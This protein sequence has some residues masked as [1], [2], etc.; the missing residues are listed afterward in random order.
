M[1]VRNVRMDAELPYLEMEFVEG[2]SVEDVVLRGAT[3]LPQALDL[4]RQGVEALRYLHGR[5]IAV[6]L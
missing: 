6:R 5:G 2:R 1:K 3:P 4:M